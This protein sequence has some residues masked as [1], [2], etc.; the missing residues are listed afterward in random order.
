MHPKHRAGAQ[1]QRRVRR[2]AHNSDAYAFFNL[3]TSPELLGEVE[4]LLPEH[5]DRLFPPTET[6]SMFLAQALSAD[7]SCQKAVNDTAV[8]RLAGG[9]P[10]C[11]T[12]TGAY[13]RARQRLPVEMISTLVRHTGRWVTVRA[14]EPW[15][16]PRR[17]ALWPV[18]P[19]RLTADRRPARSHRT[20]GHQVTT[21][22]LPAAHQ[23]TRDRQRGRPQIW[24][25]QEA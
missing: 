1:Q 13:C 12:H 18:C 6:L 8:K 7:R 21:Q 4:S 19:D 14:P 17:Q 22:T 5:R 2:H 20:Q 9:L 15:H 23:T 11:R 3:L 10:P 25:P 24:P 16:R